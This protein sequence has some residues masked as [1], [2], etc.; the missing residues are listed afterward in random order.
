M[1]NDDDYLDQLFLALSDR[2]RRAMLEMLKERELTV[3]ELGSPFGMSKQATS[4]HLAVLEKAG[5]IHKEKDGRVR[6]C[7]LNPEPLKDLSQFVEQYQKFWE[8]QFDALEEYI[9]ENLNKGDGSD[10]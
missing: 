10:S 2:K 6:R 4:K 7:V 9:N 8:D 1:N 3:N 5:F